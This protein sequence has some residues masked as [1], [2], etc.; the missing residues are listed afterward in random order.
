MKQNNHGKNCMIHQKPFV[1]TPIGN[2]HI[3]KFQNYFNKFINM[4]RNGNCRM[5]TFGRDCEVGL[6][7]R[8]YAILSGSMLTLWGKIETIVKACTGYEHKMQIIRLQT[9]E[10]IKVVGKLLIVFQY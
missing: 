9:A 3:F 4:F 6:R 8:A 10:E 5:V 1:H 2:S 7:H